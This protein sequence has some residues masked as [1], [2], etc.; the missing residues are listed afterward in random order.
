L[1]RRSCKRNIGGKEMSY[2]NKE[3]L[4]A[5]IDEVWKRKYERSNYYEFMGFLE[6]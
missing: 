5:D 1:V 4:L 6:V 3:D 2:V